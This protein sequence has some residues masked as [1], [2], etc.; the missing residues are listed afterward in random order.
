[1]IKNYNKKSN[2]FLTISVFSIQFFKFLFNHLSKKS[3]PKKMI[4]INKQK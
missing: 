2:F 1:M 4:K 3:K